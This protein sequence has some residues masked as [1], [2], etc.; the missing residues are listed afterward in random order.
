MTATA[1]R[2][3]NNSRSR[4]NSVTIP[5]T[6]LKNETRLPKRQHD[7]GAV[8]NGPH[9]P[10]ALAQL[11]LHLE[12][13]LQL[14]SKHGLLAIELSRRGRGGSRTRPARTHWPGEQPANHG[15]DRGAAGFHPGMTRGG[16]DRVTG[17]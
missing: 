13:L 4:P 10:L 11:P 5:P 12:A 14:V 17:G 7:R 8:D 15:I 16:G 1:A 9:A 6:V 2:I 3:R